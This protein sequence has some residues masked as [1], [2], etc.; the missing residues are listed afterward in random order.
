MIHSFIFASLRLSCDRIPMGVMHMAS[1]DMGLSSPLAPL[2]PRVVRS[3]APKDGKVTCSILYDFIV[4]VAARFPASSL[5]AGVRSPCLC[6]RKFF[7]ASLAV[8][9][10]THS[11]P[12][13][14]LLVLSPEKAAAGR[15]NGHNRKEVI[16]RTETYPVANLRALTLQSRRDKAA[17]APK[18][19]SE[20]ELSRVLHM[21]STM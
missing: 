13:T 5:F 1:R 20:G 11:L 7:A 4:P 18:T 9:P 6:M 16:K 15:Y 21:S 14:R 10:L 19:Y 2:S 17:N 3:P 12:H 8:L